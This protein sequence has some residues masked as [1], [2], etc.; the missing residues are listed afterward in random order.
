MNL[1]K[2]IE[3]FLKKLHE[4]AVIAYP[5][6]AVFG[7]GCNPDSKKAV[8]QLLSLKQRPIEKGLI[9][10]AAD[11]E[12]IK[13]YIA[14]EQLS[15]K[16]HEILNSIWPGPITLVLPANHKTPYWITGIF[17]S[18]AV[19]VSNYHPVK[20][21]CR[22]FKKPLVS[23]SAN[24][25]G[26]PPCRSVEEIRNQFGYQLLVYPGKVGKLQHPTEIR[27]IFTGKLIRSGE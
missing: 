23:T 25:N 15:S 12:Q 21:L 24:F 27:D 20:K 2:K 3:F 19:R 16:Q 10:I 8:M 4:D 5:T 9:L 7:L 1:K 14:D 18:V 6:E 13:P 11:Y 22:A 26:A 17:S